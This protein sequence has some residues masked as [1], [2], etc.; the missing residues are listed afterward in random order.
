MW[1]KLLNLWTKYYGVTIQMKFL[2]QYFSH[3]TVCFSASCKV[4]FEVFAYFL[5]LA[6]L[7]PRPH[8]SV[9][10]DREGLGKRR[11]GTRKN[12]GHYRD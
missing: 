7:V 2:Q 11:T 5:T 1:F 3:N 10:F 6:C 9:F 8:Y 12:F 4:K